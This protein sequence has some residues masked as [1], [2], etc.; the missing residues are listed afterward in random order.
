LQLPE[1]RVSFEKEGQGIT[2]T[3]DSVAYGVQ[4]TSSV[5]GR[6]SSNGMTLVPHEAVWIEFFPEQ[7]GAKMGDITV[8]HLAQFQRH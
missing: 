3:T 8:R 7:K 2:L 4:L 1:A 6:F 5:P